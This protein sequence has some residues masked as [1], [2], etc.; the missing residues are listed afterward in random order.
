MAEIRETCGCG[1]TYRGWD[2]YAAAWRREHQHV[3]AE[4]LAPLLAHRAA[5]IVAR[6]FVPRRLR[7]A[8]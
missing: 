7:S 2:G 6:R 8:R 4:Q 3:V 1:A 5:P